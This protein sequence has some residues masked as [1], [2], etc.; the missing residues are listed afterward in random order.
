[1]FLSEA[2]ETKFLASR[3]SEII[4]V[5]QDVLKDFGIAHVC[6]FTSLLNGNNPDLATNY[7]NDWVDHY[8][9]NGCHRIDPVFAQTWEGHRPINWEEI[10]RK[11][12]KISNFFGESKDFG[13]GQSGMTIPIRD[14]FNNAYFSI[15]SDMSAADWSKVT[16]E[17]D[18]DIR[19]FTFLFHIYCMQSKKNQPPKPNL[20]ER[21]LQVLSWAAEGK[22]AWETSQILELSE[23][24]V[25][26]YI[27][28]CMVKMEV[29][30]KTHAV[31]RAARFNLLASE[32][33][34]SGLQ[35]GR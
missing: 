24:T 6:Y 10:P 15:S 19:N 2:F 22:S 9:K 23:R 33:R 29:N 26:S 18:L 34:R 17:H 5:A 35:E 21:E 7:P 11:T 1:M 14:G 31:A 12:K 8:T 32:I 28:N 4:D 16:A 20:S 25:D 27:K 13:I 3:K 30:N